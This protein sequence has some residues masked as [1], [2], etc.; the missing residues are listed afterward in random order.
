MYGFLSHSEESLY[1][2]AWVI[3]SFMRVVPT[4]VDAVETICPLEQYP[5]KLFFFTKNYKRDTMNSLPINSWVKCFIT[6]VGTEIPFCHRG[7][8]SICL[9]W[10]ITN[11]NSNS[12]FVRICGCEEHQ[13]LCSEARWRESRCSVAPQQVKDEQDVDKLTEQ[14]KSWTFWRKKQTKLFSQ[15]VFLISFS[16]SNPQFSVYA[17][18]AHPTLLFLTLLPCF[19]HLSQPFT[20]RMARKP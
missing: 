1:F 10:F 6:S 8:L 12:K 7:L 17:F 4:P 13:M 20:V 16:P 15:F 18:Q 2:F 14:E 5:P 19:F 3:G 11:C 9:I